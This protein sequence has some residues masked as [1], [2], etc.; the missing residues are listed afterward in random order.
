MKIDTTTKDPTV[1]DLVNHVNRVCYIAGKDPLEV[2]EQ[3]LKGLR[4]LGPAVMAEKAPAKAP[5]KKAESKPV[6]A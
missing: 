5:A 6:S 2:A 3:V 1:R 4:A